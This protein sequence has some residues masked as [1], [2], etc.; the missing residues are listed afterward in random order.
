[1]AVDEVRNDLL[2]E[3]LVELLIEGAYLSI[4]TGEN[5]T[6]KDVKI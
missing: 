6:A 4:E 1:M 5:I 3:L 2:R